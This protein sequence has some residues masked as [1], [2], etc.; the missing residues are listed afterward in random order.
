MVGN[1]SFVTAGKC[2]DGC[3]GDAA[4]SIFSSKGVNVLIAGGLYKMTGELSSIMRVPAC[5]SEVPFTRNDRMREGKEG[6]EGKARAWLR[7]NL[8]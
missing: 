6:K 8:L 1:E 4:D 5:S 3:G 7:E 2:L